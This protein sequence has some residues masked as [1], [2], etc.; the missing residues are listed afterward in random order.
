M[1][2]TGNHL[3][4]CDVSVMLESLPPDFD[5]D[6]CTSVHPSHTQLMLA[7][8]LLANQVLGARIDRCASEKLP[9]SVPAWMVK[10][11]LRVWGHRD[12]DAPLWPQ[13]R[14][15]RQVRRDIRE[16][17]RLMAERWPN[18]LQGVVRLSWPINH[19]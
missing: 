14:P 5:W 17:P 7:V 10:T 1:P 12:D 19:A 4:L 18:P 3:W 6:Y 15:L 9:G 2:R 16:L 13:P 11:F 8:I